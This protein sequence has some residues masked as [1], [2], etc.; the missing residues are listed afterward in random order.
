MQAASS[1]VATNEFGPGRDIIADT[2]SKQEVVVPVEAH[3]L[4]VRHIIV[5]AAPRLREDQ[6]HDE[7]RQ[8]AIDASKAVIETLCRNGYEEVAMPLPFLGLEFYNSTTIEDCLMALFLVL[9]K[10]MVEGVP[11]NDKDGTGY[12][13]RLK[14]CLLCLRPRSF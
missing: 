14:H 13:W 2:M 8:M 7:R 5:R 4:P 6:S 11:A 1:K 3:E 9:R 12:Q 10:A